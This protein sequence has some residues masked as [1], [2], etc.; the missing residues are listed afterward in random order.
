MSKENFL[1]FYKKNGYI[2]L[3]VFDK[4]D[5]ESLKFKIKSITTKC[6]F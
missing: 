6:K 1:N 2:I 3:K 5:I 4:N